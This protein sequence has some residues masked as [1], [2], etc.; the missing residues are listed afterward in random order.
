LIRLSLSG[1]KQSFQLRAASVRSEGVSLAKD[2]PLSIAMFCNRSDISCLSS[3]AFSSL[4][5]SLFVRGRSSRWK[6]SV[7]V[8]EGSRT[9]FPKGSTA[10]LN[11]KSNEL[12][13]HKTSSKLQI[14]TTSRQTPSQFNRIY[15]I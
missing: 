14:Q 3:K 15:F 4:L 12:R 10:F 8:G 9:A 7:G 2:S 1:H 5:S 13:N 6:F 11:R